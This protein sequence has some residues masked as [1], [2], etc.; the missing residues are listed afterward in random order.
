MKNVFVAIVCFLMFFALGG[1]NM[2]TKKSSQEKGEQTQEKIMDRAS[3]S[4]PT[5]VPSN[6]LTRKAVN[7]WMHRMDVPNKTFYIY[8]LGNNGNY[9]GYYVGQTRP[10]SIC[11]LL[12]PS[13]RLEYGDRGQ[14]HGDFVVPS[15]TLDGV[16]SSGSDC[17]SY[18][19]FDAETNAYVEINGLNF[20]VS[21]QPLSIDVEPIH[22]KVDGNQ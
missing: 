3:T 10:I 17:K 20:F 12:T 22:V 5:Y 2:E 13:K 16:Y 11:T 1:C 15:P 9:I 7:K 19:F 21:D 6:F 8:L 4:V 18:Y 14:Y